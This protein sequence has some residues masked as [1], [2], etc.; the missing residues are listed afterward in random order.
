MHP[1]SIADSRSTWFVSISDIPLQA[2]D[3]KEL[4]PLQALPHL[5]ARSEALRFL[6]QLEN[7]FKDAQRAVS[8]DP[9]NPEVSFRR[10]N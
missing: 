6:G 5:L 2:L 8:I 4:Q 9:S 7:S 10:S 1:T 3:D